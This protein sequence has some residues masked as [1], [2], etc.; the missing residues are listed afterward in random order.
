MAESCPSIEWNDLWSRYQE[1]YEVK[2]AKIRG[3]IA[4]EE[5]EE[6]DGEVEDKAEASQ[7]ADADAATDLPPRC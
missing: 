4:L 3:Q 6:G 7:A 1:V 2:A 5:G